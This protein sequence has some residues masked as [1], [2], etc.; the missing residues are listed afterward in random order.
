M[1]VL[2]SVD[3]KRVEAAEV[4]DEL[5][6]KDAI[7]YQLHVKAFADSNHDGIGDFAGLT[8]KLPYLQDLGVT[9]LW[10]LPF[11]PSP[12]RDDGYDIADY[13]SVNPDFGTMKDFKRFIQEA[14]RRG[15]RVITELVVNH[16][17][18]QHRWFKRAR[19]S[20]A[21]SSARNWYVWSDTDQ[22]YQGTRIIFTD[23][24]KSNWTW[25]PEAGAFYWHRFFSHQPDLNFD[26]PRVVSAIIQVMKRWLDAGVDGFRLDAIPYLCER[27]GTSNENLP[28]THAIIKRLRQELD[29]YSK[30]KLLLAEA[31]QWPEDVQE[32]FGRGD[33]CHMAYHFPLMP[34]IYM[35]IAQEDRFPITDILRQTP[36]IPQSCQWALF[37][38]NHDELTLEMVTDVERDY[39]WSTYANDPRARINLGIRRRLAP[40]MDNDRRKIE[41]MN[42]LLLSFPGTPII[43]YGDEI[44]MGDNIYLGDRNGVRTPMQWS[45]DR[46]G[47][48]S[49]CDPARLYAPLIMDPVY[50]YEAVNVEAQS[51]SLSSLLSATKRLISVRKST[52]AFGRGT[53][54]FIR[55]ANRSVLAYVRQYHDEVIL[56]IA[57]LSRA[58]QATELDLSPWKDRI[59]QEMLGRTRFPAIGEFPYMITLGPYG[60]Y[61]FQL[62]ERD[63][64]EPVTPRAVP[65]FET[66]VVPVNS[67]WVSLA[68][69]RGVFERDV[70]PGFLSRTRWYPERSP[71][72]IRPTLTSAVPFCDI[73]DNRPWLAFFEATQRGVT[74][75][76]VMPMQIEWVR[77]DRERFNPRA[78]AAVR[79]GAREGT[80][81]DV[82]TDPIFIGLFLRNLSQSLVV[83]ENNLRLEFKPT[84]RFGA[85]TVKQPEQIRAIEQANSTALVDNQYVTKIYRLLET[86]TNPEIELGHYLTEV[87]QF[88]NTPALLGS[89]ELVEDGGRSA[90][91]VVH[92][93]VANQGDGWAVTSGY[94]DRY[95]D[96][97]RLLAASEAPR[98]NQDQVPYLHYLAQ[99]GRRLAELHIALARAEGADLAPEPVT[100]VDVARWTTD[101]LQ[102]A[103]RTFETL[104]Q[105]RNGLRETDRPLVDQ[106]LERRSALSDLLT[107]LLPSDIGGLNIRHHG[108][109]R[110][111]QILIVK[112]DVFIIDFDGNPHLPL[113]ERRRKAPAARDVA[114]LVCSIDL[115]V[116][117]ALDRAL[118]GAPDEQGRR[119]TA[120][121]EWRERATA[122][123]LTAYR[124]A[125][126]DRR[127]RTN[128]PHS[129]D[130]L[131]RFFLLDTAFDEVE[132]ELSHRPEALNAPLTGLLRIL[133]NAESE[134][135]A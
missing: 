134:A 131:L 3:E 89:A 83:E 51:R 72:Q 67:T 126:T 14:Q 91:G 36:D 100:P 112:D 46:N 50:G 20:P 5:W 16:T 118:K 73:G 62:R 37:L 53:M 132:Y 101:L 6:Y 129:A 124:E 26:N 107:R 86:G 82:A 56:C 90:V 109:F 59:P 17:S 110:L 74:S 52:L 111:G 44:G 42:S 65:E 38:R 13:G 70:L 30:G 77:F 115:A 71:K 75:R 15:L 92:A 94:L 125:M 88:A 55:P 66:L 23:T 27:E 10:L 122:T 40:L 54:T 81:L 32:Y 130:G 78:L 68:R 123:F 34:R 2:S 106:L 47:G 19:R 39:L 121:G 96:E 1:N 9:T 4:V 64:S 8:E 84:S 108:D 117:A 18:D 48:F 43:Y 133:S 7:V 76:Y 25:D 102:R 29:A 31:N 85:S 69:E 105:S 24:E 45:P 61:W 95:I 41:L 119:A 22:K 97:Q 113:A 93:Y 21:G 33:E 116:T 35:A 80:L 103:E 58:A 114:S 135:H 63:K 127:L 28:E 87:A 49:R 104:A 57:N 128:D 12:G 120:L 60:Y 99:T 98:E 11:Y 79:Q